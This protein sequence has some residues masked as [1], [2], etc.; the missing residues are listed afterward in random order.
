MENFYKAVTDVIPS[1]TD[2]MVK[3]YEKMATN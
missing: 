1:V 2:K 3:E